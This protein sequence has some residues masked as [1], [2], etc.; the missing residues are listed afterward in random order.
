MPEHQTEKTLPRPQKRQ[1]KNF[2]IDRGFQLSWVFRVSVVALLIVGVMG[3]FL[4][5][6]LVQS[7]DLVIIGQSS[8]VMDEHAHQKLVAGGEATKAVTLYVLVSSA[9]LLV[10]LLS[11]MTIVVTHKVAGPMYK[12][13]RLLRSIDDGNFLLR[14]RLRKGEEMQQVFSELENTLAKLRDARRQDV[15]QLQK[16]KT[17]LPDDDNFSAPR[18]TLQQM[19]DRYTESIGD[20]ETHQ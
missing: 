10:A 20:V 19:I 13:R 1:L 11:I 16:L 14:E 17:H 18:R 4:Y 9:V 12:I 6:T 15:L 3:Y 7:I 5:N 8:S 2:L